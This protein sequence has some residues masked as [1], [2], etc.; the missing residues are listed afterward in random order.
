MAITRTPIVDDNGTGT[1]GTV[2]DNAW[3]Q[4]F[5]NQIDAALLGSVSALLS[6][7]P[8]WRSSSGGQP[9]ISNGTLLGRYTTIGSLVWVNILLVVGS[10]TSVGGG[11][12]IF[13]LPPGLPYASNA[14]NGAGMCFQGSAYAVSGAYGVGTTEINP[15]AGAVGAPGVAMD[16]THPT[17]WASGHWMD[18]YVMYRR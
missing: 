12:W 8:G 9:S 1:T 5:Y 13:S 14:I 6:Y 15:F 10:T 11:G 18:Y 17:T 7:S 16:P 3:K 4:E 2:I